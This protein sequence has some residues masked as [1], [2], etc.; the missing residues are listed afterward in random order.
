MSLKEFAIQGSLQDFSVPTH[1]V[2]QPQIAS[3]KPNP[4]LYPSIFVQGK[5]E[6]LENGDHEI[7]KVRVPAAKV[8]VTTTNES[9]GFDTEIIV[10]PEG[11]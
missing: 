6:F 10:S 3:E 1:A 2:E 11:S 4:V 7:V 5:V 9:G 8:V